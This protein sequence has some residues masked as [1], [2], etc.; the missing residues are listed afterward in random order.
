MGNNGNLFIT[1]NNAIQIQYQVDLLNNRINNIDNKYDYIKNGDI[2]IIGNNENETIVLNNILNQIILCDNS[3]L[4]LDNTR[5]IFITKNILSYHNLDKQN[6][7]YNFISKICQIDQ[8]QKF[9]TS[10][11]DNNVISNLKI[12]NNVILGV[13]NK[14]FSIENFNFEINN[15]T[16]FLNGDVDIKKYSQLKLSLK[17]SNILYINSS[18][19]NILLKEIS[20]YPTTLNKL[21]IIKTL[22]NVYNYNLKQFNSTN[23]INKYNADNSKILFH[24]LTIQKHGQLIFNEY[25]PTKAEIN[26]VNNTLL[27]LAEN[28]LIFPKGKILANNIIS[29]QSSS[30]STTT[31][32]GTYVSTS[33][34]LSDG[35]SSNGENGGTGGGNA[36][37]GTAAYF[38]L[39]YGQQGGMDDR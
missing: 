19:E 24:T 8:I 32:D 14:N 26:E 9:N 1:N 21:K 34:F 37:K 6:S 16:A 29:H 27:L 39:N 3:N 11:F 13:L 23:Y 38:N 5:N 4:I 35:V 30:L 25:L 17:L 28:I 22:N 36:G 10:D 12:E 2:H 33:S 15:G 31:T 20:L 7:N 18:Q